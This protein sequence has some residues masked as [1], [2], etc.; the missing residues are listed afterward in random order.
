MDN[1][2]F[3]AA[4]SGAVAIVVAALSAGA[5]YLLTKRR[6][7]EADWRKMK[8]DIYRAYVIA[9]S[10]TVQHRRT[11][12]DQARYADAANSLTLVASP[13]ILKALYAFQDTVADKDECLDNLLNALRHDIS[14]SHQGMSGDLSFRLFSPPPKQSCDNADRPIGP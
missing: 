9:L 7:R 3:A 5:T 11:S 10:C 4:I 8:L 1:A 6:E 13:V 14:P 12:E 2:A